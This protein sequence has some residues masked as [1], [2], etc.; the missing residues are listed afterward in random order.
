MSRTYYELDDNVYIEGR[1]FLNGLYDSSGTEFD[2]REFRYGKS[3]A[4]GP[5]F[6]LKLWNSPQVTKVIPPLR[7][8]RRRE[9]VPVDVCYA[10]GS[11]PVVTKAVAELLGDICGADI[12]RFPIV[13]N[14]TQEDYEIINVVSLLPCFDKIHSDV[15][16]WWTE[17]DE[18][19]DKLGHPRSVRKLV[20]DS[21]VVREHH[22]F[23]IE[24]WNLYPYVS[25]ELK[26]ALQRAELT[27]VIYREIS[28]H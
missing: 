28:A 7:V 23:R 5:P 10:D 13:V 20:I 11:M 24:G 8:S 3:V 19:P 4:S 9:G 12:Q 27:G 6:K 1:W 18:R 25:K 15:E 2:G 17:A 14:G 22:M 26:D 16:S 21:S